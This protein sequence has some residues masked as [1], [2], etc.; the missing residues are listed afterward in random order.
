M[1]KLPVFFIPH[2]GGPCFFMEWPEP[3]PWKKMELFLAGFLKELPE[4][5]IALLVISAHWEE[6]TIGVSA[7]PTPQLVYDYHNFPAHTYELT[8]PAQGDPVLAGRIKQKLRADGVSCELHAER[9]FDHGVFIPLKV[10]VPDADIPTV[11]L[12][13]KSDFDPDFHLKMGASIEYVREEGVLIIASG[14]SYHNLQVM[15]SGV[16]SSESRVFDAWLT[17]TVQSEAKIRDARLQS[18]RRAP[19]ASFCHPREEHLVPLFVA[20]GA[21]GDDVGRCIFTDHV[22]GGAT[23]AYRFG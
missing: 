10:A 22:M 12:S 14:M 7:N 21:A 8:W 11:V 20:S 9:G 18:W 1:R 16:Q 4:R 5:P 6:S 3:N 17:E 15:R 23:S 19:F 2:G 13:I